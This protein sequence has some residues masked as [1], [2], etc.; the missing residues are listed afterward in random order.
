VVKVHLQGRLQLAGVKS[1]ESTKF[2]LTKI[3][4]IQTYPTT[5]VNNRP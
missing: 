5:V 4:F 2:R 1:V 3:N